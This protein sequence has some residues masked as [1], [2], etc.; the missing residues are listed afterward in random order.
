MPAVLN[1]SNE[2]AVQAFLDNRIPFLGISR[3]VEKVMEEHELAP[4]TELEAI[5]AAD[6]WARARAEEVIESMRS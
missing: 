3:L 5:L 6:A 1:A 2:V 4:A